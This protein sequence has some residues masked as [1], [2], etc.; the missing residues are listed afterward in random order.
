LFGSITTPDWPETFTTIVL[1]IRLPHA[2]LIAVQPTRGC[3]ATL[4]PTPT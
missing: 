4:S 1:K 2:V 3:F